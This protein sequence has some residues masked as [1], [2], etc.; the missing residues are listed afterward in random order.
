MQD[1]F[2][3]EGKNFHRGLPELA[4]YWMVRGHKQGGG[5]D[6]K[7]GDN[8]AAVRGCQPMYNQGLHVLDGDGSNSLAVIYNPRSLFCDSKSAMNV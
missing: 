2:F 7:Q 5:Y 3:F 8:S 1:F 4:Q 6:R